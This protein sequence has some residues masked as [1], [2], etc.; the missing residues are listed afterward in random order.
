MTR[1]FSQ[2][3]FVPKIWQYVS[4]FESGISD[5]TVSRITDSGIPYEKRGPSMAWSIS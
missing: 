3:R 4:R 2:F 1:K 5:V